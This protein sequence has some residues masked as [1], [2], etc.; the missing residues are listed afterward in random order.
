MNG[1]IKG[2]AL[3]IVATDRK[4]ENIPFNSENVFHYED[5]CLLIK[6]TAGFS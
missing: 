2:L 1:Q 5:T 6:H 3:E 4:Y